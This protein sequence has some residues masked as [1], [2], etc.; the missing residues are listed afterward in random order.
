LRLP[1]LETYHLFLVEES[2]RKA[3]VS[4]PANQVVLDTH[5]VWASMV[6]SDVQLAVDLERSVQVDD[7]PFVFSIARLPPFRC[8][9]ELRMATKKFRRLATRGGE[10]KMRENSS[11]RIRSQ[12]WR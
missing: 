4:K 2:I 8:R 5:S 1:G 3:D 12:C 7:I 6:R 10:G 9:H 11:E